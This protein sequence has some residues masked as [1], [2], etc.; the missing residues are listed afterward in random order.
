MPY[1][2]G[3]GRAIQ[4]AV[5]PRRTGMATVPKHP[6]ADYLR[7]AMVETL[8]DNEVVFDFAVQFQTDPHRMPIEDASVIWP[9][10]LSPYITVA[11][12]RIPRQEFDSSA[13]LAFARNLSYNPWHSIPEHRPLGNQGRARKSI[14]LATSKHRQAMNHDEH[15]EPTGNE[16]FD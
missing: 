9:E 1:L 11:T 15:V 2:F 12:L 6:S 10:S 14:Y 4:Y 5:K 16:I 8:A 13:Q 7:E 3:E